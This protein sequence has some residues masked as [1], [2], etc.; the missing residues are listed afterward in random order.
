MCIRDSLEFALPN[1]NGNLV[2]PQ[3][4]LRVL[5]PRLELRLFARESAFAAADVIDALLQRRHGGLQFGD[6][7]FAPED[8]GGGVA[9]AVAVEVTACEDAVPVEQIPGWRD[10]IKSSICRPAAFDGR[11]QI[12]RDQRLSQQPPQELSL[13]H[14][15]IR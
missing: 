6:L 7:I 2:R 1:G 10:K 8:G 3:F 11:R 12:R 15:S 9:G 14:I 4:R 13:I 5:Q